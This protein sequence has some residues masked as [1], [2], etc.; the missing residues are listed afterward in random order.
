MRPWVIAYAGLLVVIVAVLLNPTPQYG[1]NQQEATAYWVIRDNVDYG[2]SPG[3][4]LRGLRAN[5]TQL[6]DRIRQQA[7]PPLYFILLDGWS[8]AGSESPQVGRWLSTLLVLLGISASVSAS[9]RSSPLMATILAA[10]VLF[11]PAVTA[12]THALIVALVGLSTLWLVLW[13]RTRRRRYGVLYA[14]ALAATLYTHHIAA[15]L[16]AWQFLYVVSQRGLWRR[17]IVA[18]IAAGL[19][20]MPYLLVLQ[21]WDLQLTA[22]FWR[23]TGIALGLM[24]VPMMLVWGMAILSRARRAVQPATRHLAFPAILSVVF[25]ASTVLNIALL[26]DH[27]DWRDLINTLEDDRDPL[28]PLLI[29]LDDRH[30]LWHYD[31]LPGTVWRYGLTLDVGWRDTDVTAL[32][33]QTG[34][35]AGY[36]LTDQAQAVSFQLRS[37]TVAGDAV[38]AY[39]ETATHE[40]PGGGAAPPGG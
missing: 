10:L 28:V 23:G 6:I 12:Y 16:V 25:I 38:L 4:L 15:P 17:W 37:Q 32:L 11:Y 34:I 19:S 33:D 26:A 39:F 3:A 9:R 31:R 8:L 13:A 21:S 1:L 22:A 36:V 18:V 27:T 35:T 30:P 2:E 20:F 7:Q 5:A 40:S 29:D 24:L 14:L